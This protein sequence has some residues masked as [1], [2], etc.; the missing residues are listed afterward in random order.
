M[1]TASNKIAPVNRCHR[2]PL[3]AGCRFHRL[4]H[5]S[6]HLTDLRLADGLR[7]FLV[8]DEVSPDWLAQLQVSTAADPWM[9]GFALVHL[10][11]NAV[12]GSGGYKGP[13]NADGVVEIA[14]GVVPGYQGR[15]YVP[16][17]FFKYSLV[18][19]LRTSRGSQLVS[20]AS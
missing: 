7:D 5:D 12:I 18:R 8:S 15:G 16:S 11:D 13:P 4:I 19:C 6:R 14:Y 17:F 3:G 10:A 9:H 2:S 1:T 20:P